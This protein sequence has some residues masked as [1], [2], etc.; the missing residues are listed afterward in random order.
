MIPNKPGLILH[1]CCWSVVRTS[2]PRTKIKMPRYTM[3]FSRGGLRS[4]GRSLIMEQTRA[5]IKVGTIPTEPSYF[6]LQNHFLV[7]DVD[8]KNKDGD[9]PL[10]LACFYGSLEVT[11]VLLDHGATVDMEDDDGEPP[12]HLVSRGEYDSE[13]TAIDVARLLLER[14]ADVNSKDKNQDTPLHN[15]VFEGRLEIARTLLYHG[16][17]TST[18]KGWYNSHRA[19]YFL[20]LN[21]FLVQGIYVDAKNKYGNT[22]LH[23]T[24]FHGKLEVTRMLLDH[25]VTVDMENEEGETPLHLVSRGNYDSEQTGIDVAWLL[26]EHGA[27]VNSKDKNQDTPLH[28]AIFEGRLEIARMLLY[29]G[30]NTSTD[31]GWYNSHRAKYFLLLNHFLVQGIDVDAKNKYGNAPLHLTCFY[32]KLEVTRM[33]LDHGATVDMENEEGETPLHQVSRGNY[34]SEQTGVDIARLLL[35]H[36][37]DVNSKDKDQDTPLHNATCKGRLE[38][39]RKLLNHGANTSTDKG[40]YNSH[41]AEY[42]KRN[43]TPKPF[44]SAR[45]RRK[46]Q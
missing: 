37:A 5:Q 29:H 9:S 30:A 42:F 44:S 32:G 7:Q 24:C 25:G 33:L 21:H 34:R 22:P 40:W 28:N 14:G 31:K 11:Q 18:D 41:R 1:G 43:L 39:A 6:L 16:T 45:H 4:Q 38:I 3:L 36:G 26:L 15:A 12:L 10:H 19:K 27:D 20:L 8:A 46:R 23:L 2:I 35:E 17:N 13:Q